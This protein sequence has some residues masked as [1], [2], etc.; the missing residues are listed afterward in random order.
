MNEIRDRLTTLS[1]PGPLMGIGTW[2]IG[3]PTWATDGKPIGWG[4]VD[5]TESIRAIHAALDAGVRL[6]DTADVYG[7][8]HSERLIGRAIDGRRDEVVL[9]SKFGC[10]FDEA[11][12][13][14]T[15]VME[16]A[17]TAYVR[18]ACEGSLRR[19]GVERIDVYLL[20][21][22]E[23]PIEHVEPVRETLAEL[24]AEGKIASY[25][26]ST[27]EV[28]KARTMALD[29]GCSVV[30]MALN[31]FNDAQLGML[32]LCDELDLLSLNR[33]ALAMGLLTGTYDRASVLPADD[34]RGGGASWLTWFEGGRPKPE[35]LDRLDAVREILTSDGRTLAQGALAWIWGRSD[36][37]VPIP[38]FRR[39]DQIVDL[40]GA[41]AFGPLA[42]AQMTEVSHLLASEPV[43]V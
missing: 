41:R 42:P 28:A 31:L 15:G 35:L 37:T 24:V 14:F 4:E 34:I 20:H 7:A 43:P 3:G 8:G 10:L 18:R 11:T 36:R 27:D 32:E 29:P 17:D 38:G 16:T 22:N 9:V 30:E 40:A 2:A 21:P 26:W 19:L 39:L 6:I 13:T 33:S 12:R 23:F 25:G 1:G 5:D